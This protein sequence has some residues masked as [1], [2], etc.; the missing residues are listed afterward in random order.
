MIVGLGMR[1]DVWLL[2]LG[3]LLLV[4]GILLLVRR[5][6]GPVWGGLL[7]VLSVLRLVVVRVM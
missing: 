2:I 4:L 6:L 3:I 5:M 1:L 7:L